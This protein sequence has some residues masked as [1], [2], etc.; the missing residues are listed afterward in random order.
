MTAKGEPP[1]T[2]ST[3]GAE[4]PASDEGLDEPTDETTIEFDVDAMGAELFEVE[5]ASGRETTGRAIVAKVIDDNRSTGAIA[6]R[7]L[8]VRRGRRSTLVSAIPSLLAKSMRPEPVR[9]RARSSGA[10]PGARTSAPAGEPADLTQ[11]AV[12]VDALAIPVESESRGYGVEVGAVPANVHTAPT[13]EQVIPRLGT[14]GTLVQKARFCLDAGDVTEAVL[15]ASAA[16][17]ANEQSPEVDVGDLTD[18]AG[19]PLAPIFTAGPISKVP[20]MNRSDAELDT[21]ALDELHWALLRRMNGHLTLDEVFRATKIPAIDALKIA[22]SLL[23]EGV[24]RVQDR[25]GA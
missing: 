22:A 17:A 11:P 2:G 23:R 20:V 13:A 4:Q 16:V 14:V 15:A 9:P 3:T 7:E 8:A 19:G 10:P 12:D 5:A 25:T 1:T 24:I 6:T 18:M 21:M